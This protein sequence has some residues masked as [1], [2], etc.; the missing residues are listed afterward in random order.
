MSTH[1]FYF[2]LDRLKE[3]QDSA[4]SWGNFALVCNQASL[5]SKMQSSPEILSQINDKAQL[6]AIWGPQH[7]YHGTAQDNMMETQD[8]TQDL[9]GQPPIYSLYGKTRQPSQEMLQGLDSIIFDI[10]LSGTRVYTYKA[11]LKAILKAAKHASLQVVVLDRPNPL[12][13][14]YVSGRVLDDQMRSFVGADTMPMRHGLTTA[15]MALFLNRK[16]GAELQIIALSQ[17]NPEKDWSKLDKPWILTSPN[18]P[19]SSSVLLYPGL[20]AVEG[21]NLSEGR[22]TT[23][24]FEVIGSHQPVNPKKIK[25]RLY[26]LLP[27]LDGIHIRPFTFEPTFSK[28]SGH[29]CY[30]LQMFVEDSDLFCSFHLGLALIKSYIDLTAK[31]FAYKAPPYEY[32]LNKNP[33][34][35]ILG[36]PL[37]TE[38]LEQYSKTDLF[39]SEGLDHYCKQVSPYL[40]YPRNLRPTAPN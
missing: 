17:W 34:N 32:E 22:G 10:Q 13:G 11:T 33:M 24:P 2:G 40:I 7:G 36:S 26:D 5:N 29:T 20:V 25:Q 37:A 35:L 38:K 18:L 6:K 30:G 21:C 16:I 9:D 23:T 3:I 39:W 8:Q 1:S 14:L 15:E 19:T 4:Q 31:S 12:G 28:W 27:G